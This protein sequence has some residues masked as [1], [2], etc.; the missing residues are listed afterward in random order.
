MKVNN[1][2]QL[3]GK[4]QHRQNLNTFGPTNLPKGAVVDEEHLNAL[5]KQLQSILVYWNENND[6]GGALVSVHYKHV[7]A[8][9]NRLKVLLAVKVNHR[10]NPLEVLS[11][12]GKRTQTIVLYRNM[13]LL[14]MY[15][16]KP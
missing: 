3:K 5:A 13:Y 15:H 2:L 16:W 4:F 6:I 9:S 1:I 12:S 14:I 11:L 8:K 7:V 10:T